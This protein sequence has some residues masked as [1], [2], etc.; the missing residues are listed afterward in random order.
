[1]FEKLVI[2]DGANHMLG[3]MASVVAKELMN[4]QKVVI[5][6][7]EEISVSGSLFRNKLIFSKFL[8]HRGSTNPKRGPLHYRSPARILWRTIRGMMNHK[9]QRGQAA[10][11]RL[12][13]FEGIPHPFDKL[14]RQVIPAALRVLRLK[15]GRKFCRLG[16]LSANVG[17]GHNDLIARL[18]EK[19]KTKSEAFY[20]RKKQLG[21]LRKQAETTAYAKLKIELPTKKKIVLDAKAVKGAKGAAAK[22]AKGG[23][24]AEATDAKP[25]KAAPAD[26]GADKGAKGDKA[27]KG[28]KGGDKAKGGDDKAAK[29][30]K[31]AKGG[32][33]ADKGAAKG[34]DAA[35]GAKG[36]KGGKDKQ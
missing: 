28:A 31:G 11:D 10:M 20:G 7:A 19:R 16:D 8:A 35:K 32:D 17:W 12:K 18:E 14:K 9:K 3:R 29:A 13:V 1:M 36:G 2:V 30:D 6:R 21:K 15:P 5:V 33:K 22:G 25:T 23:K 26:K 34:G 27:D 24:P 4:G